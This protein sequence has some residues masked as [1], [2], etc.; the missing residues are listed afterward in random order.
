MTSWTVCNCSL[1]P[2]NLRYLHDS[3]A[4]FFLTARFSQEDYTYDWYGSFHCAAIEFILTLVVPRLMHVLLQVGA[5]SYQEPAESE[6]SPLHRNLLWVGAESSKPRRVVAR[7]T[8][9]SPSMK[10]T[11]RTVPLFTTETDDGNAKCLSSEILV[12]A[13]DWSSSS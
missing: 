1:G 8:S 10:M 11:Q 3:S 9:H 4:S 13:L 7:M 5:G 2:A 12:H 6:C